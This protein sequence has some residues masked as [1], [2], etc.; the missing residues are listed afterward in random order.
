MNFEDTTEMQM[1]ERT[2]KEVAEQFDPDYWLEKEEAGE[3]AMQFWNELANAGFTGLVVPE[4]YGGSGMG[5]KEM[6]VAIATMSE[7]GCGMAPAWFLVV[8]GHMIGH[9]ISEHG[10]EA[11]KE[12]H[13]PALVDGDY[14][15]SVGITEPNTGFNTLNM[16]T[17]AERDGDEFIING[18]KCWI[19]FSDRAKYMLLLARTTPPEEV[20]KNSRGVSLFIVDLDDSA[21]D[22][23]PIPK[24][25]FNYS[26]SCEIF[27]DDLRIHEDRLVGGEDNGWPILLEAINPERITF[28]AA[29]TG[30]GKL[31][32]EHAIDY[33][34]EREVFDGPIG[35]YQAIQ[36]PIAETMAEM[37][38]AELIWKKAAWLYDTGREC[39]YESNVSKIVSANSAIK[40]ARH[41][42]Q[43]F[44]GW[45]YAKEYHVERWFRELTS[46]R[47][48]P[49]S[50]EMALN[51]MAQRI[52]FP[53]SY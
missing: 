9:T 43:T 4:E 37:E 49:V 52:G 50:K 35:Q 12:R 11:Q 39:G 40:A 17:V 24:H 53:K 7:H 46:Q 42:M 36:H 33:A 14:L 3:Y 48:A 25:A 26:N 23:K 2:A 38:A 47:L 32:A 29:S 10:D 44:G 22:V 1:V 13:L 15:W 19:S 8:P 27:I 51:H 21:L 20:E 41:A 30:T 28:A 45:G 31:A 5:I 34:N 18:Q 6:S 16:E